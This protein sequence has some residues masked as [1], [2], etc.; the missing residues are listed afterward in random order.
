MTATPQKR[1]L[2]NHKI[3]DIC[4]HCDRRLFAWRNVDAMAERQRLGVGWVVV[5]CRHDV[6]HIRPRAK[7]V[8]R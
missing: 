6:F 1:H 4:R 8:R 3:A 7:D 2:D 5:H